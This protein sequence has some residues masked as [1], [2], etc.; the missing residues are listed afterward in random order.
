MANGGSSQDWLPIA[1]EANMCLIKVKA[2]MD[3]PLLQVK[4]SQQCI[5]CVEAAMLALYG[6]YEA[7]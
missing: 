3:R 4:R 6:S 7:R 2:L 5:F 1:F